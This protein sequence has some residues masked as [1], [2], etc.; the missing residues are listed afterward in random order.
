M[1]Q[2]RSIPA[3]T[4][5]LALFVGCSQGDKPQ[6]S[7]TLNHSEDPA[8]RVTA[9]PARTQP[10]AKP[11]GQAVITQKPRR[12]LPDPLRGR[13][14]ETMNAGAYTYI[15]LASDH[16]ETWAA[17][18]VFQ[19]DVGDEV[20]IAGLAPMKNFK[21]SSL[22]RTF[23]SIQFA[24]AARVVG[25]DGAAEPGLPPGHALVEGLPPGHMPIGGAGAAAT[26]TGSATVNP[27]KVEVLSDGITVAHLFENRAN[28]SG[29]VVRFRGRVVKANRGIL[30]SNWLHIQDGTGTPGTNDITVTS[31]TGYAAK[32]S[33][34]VIEGTLG[35]YRDFGA[36]Y[37][38]DVIVE[39]ATVTVESPQ[40]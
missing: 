33:L 14:K 37:T 22:K 35:L 6:P 25:D 28:L 5:L 12:G 38:Y 3:G 30:G 27:G 8:P 34:V 39:S 10:V 7:A 13:V 16:G 21:S 11:Q 1:V 26:P 20:E 24:G 36:G 31:K 29:K 23:E 40:P 15:L 18:R 17:A 9:E 2:I 19:V 32:G 4:L